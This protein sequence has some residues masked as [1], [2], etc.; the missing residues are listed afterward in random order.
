MTVRLETILGE[1]AKEA[2]SRGL[3]ILVLR[4]YKLLPTTNVG[5]DIDMAITPHDLAAWIGILKAVALKHSLQFDRGASYRYSKQFLLG[6][7]DGGPLEID[8]E[9]RFWWRGIPWLD[10][11][12]V[13]ENAVRHRDYIWRPTGSHEFVITFNHSYLHGGFFPRKYYDWLI[14]LLET[15]EREIRP[16]MEWIYGPDDSA[17]ILRLIRAGEIDHLDTANRRIRVD[18]LLRFLRRRPLRLSTGFVASYGYDLWLRLL[19]LKR[20][21]VQQGL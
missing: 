11:E 19:A 17:E 4:N 3:K 21:Q 20:A 1:I 8:L 6:S 15:A 12:A 18:C 2:E 16:L 13:I 7:V 5:H 14:E 10:E 9:P